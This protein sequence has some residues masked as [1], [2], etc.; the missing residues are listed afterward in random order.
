MCVVPRYTYLEYFSPL[1]THMCAQFEIFAKSTVNHTLPVFPS[2]KILRLHTC[3]FRQKEILNSTCLSDKKLTFQALDRA[4][5][6][7][8]RKWYARD[9]RRGVLPK[10]NR[11]DEFSER[12][13]PL[14][15]VRRG[16]QPGVDKGMESVLWQ[17]N[18]LSGKLFKAMG[19]R[20]LFL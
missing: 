7:S 4:F 6:L 10:H 19:S 20:R 12:Y 18:Q 14:Y 5:E 3:G 2:C 13:I 9:V 8:V 15:S 11:G 17:N 1:L 16:W